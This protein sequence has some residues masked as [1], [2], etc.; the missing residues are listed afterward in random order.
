MTMEIKRVLAA[1]LLCGGLAAGCNWVTLTDAGANVQLA[2][3][4][5][6]VDCRRVGAV[7]ASTRDRVLVARH[8]EKVT[9]ELIVLASNQAAT[10]GGDTIV[11]DGPPQDGAQSYG[12]YRCR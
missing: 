12:V 7:S 5:D 1:T 11:A 4:A 8:P 6:V 9:A 2:R 3:A 10:I